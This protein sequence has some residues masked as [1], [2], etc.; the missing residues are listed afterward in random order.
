MMA[1]R[2]W[3]TSESTRNVI[4]Y[5]RLRLVIAVCSAIAES[6]RPDQL[7]DQR[8]SGE[9]LRFGR[10]AETLA[11]GIQ[12]GVQDQPDQNNDE[13]LVDDLVPRSEGHPQGEQ[14]A[15][16]GDRKVPGQ[17]PTLDTPTA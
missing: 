13:R 4:A 10:L 15:R 14:D 12:E 8:L 11:A 7:D 9:V 16:S 5:S 6:F 2:S 17:L 1:R 3:P